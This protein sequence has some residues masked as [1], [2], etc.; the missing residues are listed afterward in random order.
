MPSL[1]A[2]F[3]VDLW[4]IFFTL[5]LSTYIYVKL[6]FDVIELKKSLI[7]IEQPERTDP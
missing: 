4:H 6:L 1:F 7:L 5:Q 2:N 3:I